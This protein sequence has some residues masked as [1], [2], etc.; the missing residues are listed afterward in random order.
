MYKKE[1]LSVMGKEE[2]A[3][4]ARKLELSPETYTT[5]E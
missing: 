3:D 1:E 2:L 5:N 4:I